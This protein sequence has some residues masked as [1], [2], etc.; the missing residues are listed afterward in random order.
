MID[1]GLR[2]PIR[3]QQAL[4]DGWNSSVLLAGWKSLEIPIR[5]GTRSRWVV[6]S[7]GQDDDPL[8]PCHCYVQPGLASAPAAGQEVWCP[9]I[10]GFQFPVVLDVAGFTHVHVRAVNVDDIELH[11]HEVGSDHHG[12]NWGPLNS[13]PKIAADST[14]EEITDAEVMNSADFPDDSTG[15]TARYC[16]IHWESVTE[17]LHFA[18]TVLQVSWAAV[19][20]AR[21]MNPF[22]LCARGYAGSSPRA[23]LVSGSGTFKIRMTPLENQ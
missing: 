15:E 17:H 21:A 4:D 11:V 3:V 12:L 6:V 9:I 10:H 18:P 8:V 20:H 23:K 1:F 14:F 16:L 19:L 2:K 5:N 13:P 7:A 22:L